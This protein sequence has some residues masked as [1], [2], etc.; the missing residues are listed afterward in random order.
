MTELGVAG[1]DT[2]YIDHS[3]TTPLH[4][5]VVDGMLAFPREHF[6]NPSTGHVEACERPRRSPK[7][8]SRLHPLSG[9][10]RPARRS[11]GISPR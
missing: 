10:A 1:S 9:S 6:G 11:G 2:I 8:A 7:L 5:E 3:A 4:P